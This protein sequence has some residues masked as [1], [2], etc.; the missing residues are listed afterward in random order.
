MGS[1]KTPFDRFTT[2]IEQDRAPGEARGAVLLDFLFE[3]EH[4][5]SQY[6]LSR[7]EGITGLVVPLSVGRTLLGSVMVSRVVP[8]PY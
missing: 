5:Q 1:V 3:V 2:T 7:S 8:V 4:F 6:V